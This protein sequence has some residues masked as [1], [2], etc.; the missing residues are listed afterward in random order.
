MIEDRPVDLDGDL[1]TPLG[2]ENLSVGHP[3]RRAS[4]DGD[5]IAPIHL[6]PHLCNHGV[7]SKFELVCNLL[8]NPHWPMLTDRRARPTALAYKAQPPVR[9][10]SQMRGKAARYVHIR[11]PITEVSVGLLPRVLQDVINL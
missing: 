2:K 8:Q 5:P 10:P 3:V 4:R 9:I 6:L 11:G 1:L 7:I